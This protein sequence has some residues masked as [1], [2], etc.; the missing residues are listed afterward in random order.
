MFK[1]GNMEVFTGSDRLMNTVSLAGSTGKGATYTNG[2]YA[3]ADI[4]FG[5]AVKFGPVVEHPLNANVIPDGNKGFL[6]R[7]WNRVFKAN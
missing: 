4:Y 7:L 1:S 2:S 3:G 5:F 6:G